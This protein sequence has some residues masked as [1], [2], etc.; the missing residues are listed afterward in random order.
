MAKVELKLTRQQVELCLEAF[1]FLVVNPEVEEVKDLLRAAVNF[2][3][4]SPTQRRI[5]WAE[6]LDQA[7]GI[8]ADAD[9]LEIRWT[10]MN[11]ARKGLIRKRARLNGWNIY[12]AAAFWA[13]VRSRLIPFDAAYVENWTGGRTLDTFLRIPTASKPRDHMEEYPAWVGRSRG[14]GGGSSATASKSCESPGCD[15]VAGFTVNGLGRVCFECFKREKR[16]A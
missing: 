5:P 2:M 12:D 1:D 6:H 15:R 4:E 14:G 8:Y 9:G 3:A 10:S 16:G 11:E 7:K 13:E